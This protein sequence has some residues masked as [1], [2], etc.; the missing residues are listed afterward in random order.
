MVY[1][2]NH[3]DRGEDLEFECENELEALRQFMY[4]LGY[5]MEVE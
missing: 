4:A 1:I 5:N 3:A 2:F